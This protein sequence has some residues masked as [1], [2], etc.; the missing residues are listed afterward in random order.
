MIRLFVALKIPEN[1]KEQLLN[2]CNELVPDASLYRWET[3]D[4]IH[5][6]LK[7]IG[8]VEENLV[9]LISKE[10]DFV[11]KYRS[12][13]FKISKFGFFFRDN[14]P[15]ILWAGLQTDESIFKLVEEINNRLEMFDIEPEKKK[16]KAHLTLMRIK[17]NFDENYIN[18]FNNYQFDNLNFKTNKIV[19]VKS[20]LTQAGAQHT[21]IKNYELI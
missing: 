11:K 4:K 3:T 9:P 12:F 2:I 19:L 15:K 20:D 14:R 8:E 5:L 6:T 10:L 16:F 7:F 21:E 13:D 17:N 18:N 1:I